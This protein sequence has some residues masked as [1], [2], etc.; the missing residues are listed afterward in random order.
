VSIKLTHHLVVDYEL[1]NLPPD[2]RKQVQDV[3]R[4]LA[5][6]HQLFPK[7]IEVGQFGTPP[8][9]LV[10]IRREGAAAAWTDAVQAAMK[11]NVVRVLDAA[12]KQE[13]E[14][15][16]AGL[17]LGER[18]GDV[19]GAMLDG[20]DD[21]DLDPAQR[22]ARRT[23]RA[24]LLVDIE[25]ALKNA[26]LSEPA[27]D[28]VDTALL[29]MKTAGLWAIWAGLLLKIVEV[30]VCLPAELKKRMRALL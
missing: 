15:Q 17:G 25:A 11:A 2:W 23:R 6:N 13:I 30:D 22:L 16:V 9:V 14:R 1:K 27:H 18:K 20:Y 12:R 28:V 26:E 10:S 5:S 21:R 7:L 19:A 29:H 3:V 4:T 8:K 24:T